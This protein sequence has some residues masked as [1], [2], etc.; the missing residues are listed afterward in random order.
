MKKTAVMGV[1]A[2]VAAGSLG[3]AAPARAQ[4]CPP[5]IPQSD[6]V[7]LE[8]GQIR[9]NP[10]NPEEDADYLIDETGRCAYAAVP[11]QVWC[12]HT[13]VYWD[14]YYGDYV[15]QDYWTGDYVI[16]YGRLSGDVN[17]CL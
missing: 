6:T 9:V 8:N 11:P 3:I 14:F 17:N 4:S 12:T 15:Y 16:D 1:A 2:L 10:G 7:K 5:G 13:F